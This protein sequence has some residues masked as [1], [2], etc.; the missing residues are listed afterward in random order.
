MIIDRAKI[1]AKNPPAVINYDVT[2]TL[3]S[4]ISEAINDLNNYRTLNKKL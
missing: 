1:I 3:Y 4:E 2:L